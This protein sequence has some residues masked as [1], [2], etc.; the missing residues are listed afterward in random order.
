M[1]FYILR[2][3]LFIGHV[4]VYADVLEFLV[5]WLLFGLLVVSNTVEAPTEHPE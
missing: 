3:C 5:G 4:H 2:V 1:L